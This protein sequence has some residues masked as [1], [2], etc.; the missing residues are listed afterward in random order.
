MSPSVGTLTTGGLYTA[1]ATISG[2]Q[3]ITI[4]ATSVADTTKSASATVTLAQATTTGTASFTT[5]DTTTQGTWKPVYGA[6]GYNVINNAISYPTDVTVTPTGTTSFTWATT[7]S[8]VRALSK[9]ASKPDRI[10]ATWFN[11]SSFVIDL[12]FSDSLQHRLAL[13]LLDWDLQSRAETVTVT[14][15]N[16]VVLDTRSVTAFTAGEYLVW[17]LSGHVKIRVTRT[18]GPNAVVSGL[19]FK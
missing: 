1:P 12:A 15:A 13:Y 7:T 18:A 5:L 17:Q 10:A 6:D 3:T 8:D 4:T 9:A 14:D 16:G 2:T 11:S 19:F